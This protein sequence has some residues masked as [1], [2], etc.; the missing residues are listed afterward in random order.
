MGESITLNDRA[1]VVA[2]RMAADAAALNITATRLANGARVLDCGIAAP[3]GLAAGL[4]FS[5]ACMGGLGHLSLTHIALD[6]WQLPAV[7][8]WTDRPSVA[9][10]ASQ[11]AGW[12]V[13]QDGFF[14]MGSGPARA[15]IRAEAKLYEQLAYAE[16]SDVAVLCLEGRTPPGAEIAGF[17]AERAGVAPERLALLIAPTASIAGSVQVAAR[18]AETGLHKLHELGFDIGAVQSAFATC[19]IAP[20][21]KSDMRAIGR[22]N[23]GILYA[24]V[25]HYTVRADDEELAA[26][27]ERVPSSSSSD[28]GRTFYEIFKSYDGDFYKIDPMLFSPAEVSITNSATGRTFRAGRTNAEVLRR[29]YLE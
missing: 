27:V 17:I 13:N 20:V 2:E 24:G 6:G 28:Y 10:M 4:Q 11:Y 29:S 23:D 1:W 8:V 9:C 25:A 21:A 26:L 12:M 3:G 7:Q 14:A 18:I 15:L 5:A 19:P 16:R 22:T